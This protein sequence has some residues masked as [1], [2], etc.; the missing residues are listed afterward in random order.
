MSVIDNL[1]LFEMHERERQRALKRLPVCSE[2]G[3]PITDEFC[4]KINGNLI[5]EACI[6]ECRVEVEQE[7]Q[8]E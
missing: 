7:I 1:D 4:Y 8:Y 6:D 3:E 5:C 2:C